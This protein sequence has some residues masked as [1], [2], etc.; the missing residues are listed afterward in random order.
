MGTL[1]LSRGEYDNAKEYIN[2]ALVIRIQ[3]GDKKGEAADYGNLGAVFQSLGEY[4]KAEEYLARA[5]AIRIQIGDKKG[6]AADYTK[7]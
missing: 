4:D 7:T 2:R 6:E 3:I 1:F 5:L